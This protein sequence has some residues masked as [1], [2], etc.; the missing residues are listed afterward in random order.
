MA[1]GGSHRRPGDPREGAVW[2]GLKERLWRR[3]T[4]GGRHPA[5]CYHCSHPIV[6]GLGEIQHL[7]SPRQFPQYAMT[8]SNLKPSHGG[9]R[10]RCQTCG[11]ACNAVAAGNAAARDERGRPLPFTAQF[12]RD[13]QAR[14]KVSAG[15]ASSRQAPSIAAKPARVPVT[16]VGRPW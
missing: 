12:I 11:L 2:T 13:A 8:E 15:R 6:T 9:G 14:T 16:D 1:Q 5:T 10:R 3:W 7:L 4:D